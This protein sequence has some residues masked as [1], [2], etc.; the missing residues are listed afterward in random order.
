MPY[1]PAT[2][3][4]PTKDSIEEDMVEALVGG[5]RPELKLNGL[6]RGVNSVK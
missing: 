5:E 3:V 4:V 2:A 6:P 1:S